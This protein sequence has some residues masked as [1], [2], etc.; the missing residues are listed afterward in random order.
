MKGGKGAS[1]ITVLATQAG[2][3]E[4]GSQ[5]PWKKSEVAAEAPATPV[6]RGTETGGSLGLAQPRCV[7]EGTKILDIIF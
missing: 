1:V 3:A 5:N 4:C 6:L 2:R 7:M